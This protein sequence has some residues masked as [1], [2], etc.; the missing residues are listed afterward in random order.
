VRYSEKGKRTPSVQ[1]KAKGERGLEEM[2]EH[3]SDSEILFGL[4]SLVIQDTHKCV[5]ILWIGERSPYV[6]KGGLLYHQADIANFYQVRELFKRPI[7]STCFSI[8]MFVIPRLFTF[9]SI[10]LWLPIQ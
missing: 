4:V 6:V 9:V 1:L 3:L 2:R 7:F 8:S 5:F 10:V